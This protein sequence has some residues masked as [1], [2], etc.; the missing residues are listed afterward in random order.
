MPVVLVTRPKPFFCVQMIVLAA[1]P[2][3][4]AGRVFL[5]LCSVVR[6]LLE[7]GD[8]VDRH[9]ILHLVDMC[10][11]LCISNSV[12]CLFGLNQRTAGCGSAQ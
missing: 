7:S 2:G 12:H 1:L 5:V 3:R 4:L 8:V 10:V 9:G 6:V 11:L